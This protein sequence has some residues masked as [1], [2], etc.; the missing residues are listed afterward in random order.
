VH[1]LRPNSSSEQ[2]SNGLQLPT[3]NVGRLSR[4]DRARE[5]TA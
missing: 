3:S 1:H 2:T 5:A 4:C